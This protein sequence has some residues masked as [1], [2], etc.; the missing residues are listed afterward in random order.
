MSTTIKA[1]TKASLN[2]QIN[3][4]LT[5]EINLNATGN[6]I[7]TENNFIKSLFGPSG[8]GKTSLLRIILGLNTKTE[9]SICFNE[10]VWQSPIDK[11]FIKTNARRV[12][13]VPQRDCLFPF[14]NVRENITYAIESWEA[15]LLEARLEELLELFQ[16]KSLA[17]RKI[18]EISGG[19][20]QRVSLARAVAAQ[21]QLL[22]LDEAF[23]SLDSKS[24]KK[25][26]PEISIWL[27]QLKIPAIVVSHDERDAQ[28]L[29]SEV[30]HFD[31]HNLKF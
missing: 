23:S 6:F 14:K 24:R 27:H 2:L 18:S 9:S 26:L 31:G 20:K 4:L 22:L 25:L 12:G 5:D 17:E 28:L 16:I 8:C 15:P 21:P 29:A 1:T 11:I 13:F 10:S 19:Q 30:F 7:F 3:Y